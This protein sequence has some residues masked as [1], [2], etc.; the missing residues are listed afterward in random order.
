MGSEGDGISMLSLSVTH[1]KHCSIEYAMF[2]LWKKNKEG[3]SETRKIGIR[4]EKLR[5]RGVLE[6]NNLWC[7]IACKPVVVDTYLCAPL[8]I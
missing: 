6:A 4:Q 2:I 1:A 8:R 3:D 5:T 7:A